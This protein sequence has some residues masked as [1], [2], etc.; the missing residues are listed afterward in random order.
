MEILIRRARMEDA[1]DIARLS[2]ELAYPASTAQIEDRLRL[3][4]AL[5][6]FNPTR[7]KKQYGVEI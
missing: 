5:K 4:L 6:K 7:S 3:L 1:A 2:G